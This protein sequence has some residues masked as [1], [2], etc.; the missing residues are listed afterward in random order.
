MKVT[1]KHKKTPLYLVI[2]FFMFVSNS[3][4]V[5]QENKSDCNTKNKNS[6]EVTSGNFSNLSNTVSVLFVSKTY[7]PLR[8]LIQVAGNNIEQDDSHAITQQELQETI[9]YIHNEK[10]TYDDLVKMRNDLLTDQNFKKLSPMQQSDAQTVLNDIISVEATMNQ[11][12][13][14]SNM[15]CRFALADNPFDEFPKD[16]IFT[17]GIK[18]DENDE[19][20]ETIMKMKQ[21]RSVCAFCWYKKTRQANI[22]L[23]TTDR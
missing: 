16:S 5:E 20:Q 4:A 1:F 23:R 3:F 13:N 7:K 17:S 6:L 21:N 10:L 12:R 15:Y 14:L 22:S 11:H 18:S 8:Y 2:T 9:R 19:K